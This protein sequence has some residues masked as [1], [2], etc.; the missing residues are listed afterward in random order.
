M[1]KNNKKGVG[2][3]K[4]VDHTLQQQQSTASNAFAPVK[5]KALLV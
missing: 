4:T 3:Q 5:T 1:K 2:P